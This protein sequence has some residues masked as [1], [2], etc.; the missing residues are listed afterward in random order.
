MFNY[1]LY[2]GPLNEGMPGLCWA[3]GAAYWDVSGHVGPMLGHVE[4][5]FWQ[6]SRFP[7]KRVEQR[8]DS[9]EIKAYPQ[10]KA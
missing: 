1:M 6:L 8:Q 3:Y 4:P 2:I 9:A 10:A 5:K 7:F